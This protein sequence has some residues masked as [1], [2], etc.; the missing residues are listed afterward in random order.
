MVEIV[1]KKKNRE[2]FINKI[3]ES[4]ILNEI[5]LEENGYV[6]KNSKYLVDLENNVKVYRNSNESKL[7]WSKVEKKN[8]ILAMDNEM[9]RTKTG[10]ELSRITIINFEGEVLYDQLVKPENEI[11]D[12][13][14]KFSGMT[15]ELLK[16]VTKNL[17]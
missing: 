1:D 10:L 3:W 14:T 9:V 8:K 13:N 7:D 15:Y 2:H 17:K 12:Y 6:A 16:D 4:L 11:L 5:E